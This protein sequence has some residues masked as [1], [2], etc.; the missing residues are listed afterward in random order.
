[1][2]RLEYESYIASRLTKYLI[3]DIHTLGRK[4]VEDWEI[5]GRIYRHIQ[6]Y[7]GFELDYLDE[8]LLDKGERGF[9]LEEKK[10]LVEDY[11]RNLDE[12]MKDNYLHYY[13]QVSEFGVTWDQVD[14][15]VYI[16][17][18]NKVYLELGVDV[19]IWI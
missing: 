9:S 17:S 12:E 14:W 15:R 16:N 1:M 11:M 5:E 19:G 18:E 13:L 3:I 6:S 4:R 10:Q 2:N 7:V 8:Y